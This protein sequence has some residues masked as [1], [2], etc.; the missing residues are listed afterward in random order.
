MKNI[1]TN[2]EMI[3]KFRKK[4]I[5]E[6]VNVILK[7]CPWELEANE[8]EELRLK[9]IKQHLKDGV[10]I[11]EKIKIYHVDGRCLTTFTKVNL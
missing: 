8:I 3:L 6:I 7:N 4:S 11:P 10:C 2:G 9:K 1:Y 5:K